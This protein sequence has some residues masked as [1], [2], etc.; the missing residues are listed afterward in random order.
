MRLSAPLIAPLAA[1]AA[2]T[3]LPAVAADYRLPP[4]PP[5]YEGPG[6]QGGVFNWGGIYGGIHGG[7][8]TGTIDFPNYLGAARSSAQARLGLAT[9]GVTL[10]RD[11]SDE[12][13]LY[14]GFA[15]INWVW[16]DVMVGVEASYT[17][18]NGGFNAIGYS[19]NGFAAPVTGVA[20]NRF[21]LQDYAV[22][23]FR[24]GYPMGRLMPYAGLGIAFGRGSYSTTYQAVDLTTNTTVLGGVYNRTWMIGAAAS[25]G[26]EYALLDNL[27]LRT[28]Y[29]WVGFSSTDGAA[30]GP[31]IHT[32]RAGI[33]VKY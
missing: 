15:G 33:G 4:P 32:I 18:F 25:L 2:L 8:S 13:P 27:L 10:P 17:S 19:D 24:A 9:P 16:D 30:S 12:S 1:V 29:Q 6:D 21:S 11:V 20:W 7:Y 3:A 14:G 31:G 28:E 22:V 26:L 5:L 23:G